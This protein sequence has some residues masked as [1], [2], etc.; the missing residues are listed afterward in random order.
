MAKLIGYPPVGNANDETAQWT[1]GGILEWTKGRR[2]QYVKTTTG[3]LKG[4]AVGWAT[5]SALG[6]V[7]TPDRSAVI[8]I[9]AVK[10]AAGMILNTVTAN[11]YTWI[12]ISGPTDNVAKTNGSIVVDNPINMAADMV[13]GPMAG[14]GTLAH[15][16]SGYAM[17]TDSG[18]IAKLFLQCG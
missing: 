9:D 5:T 14:T 1:L 8:G 11:Y 18:S 12:Q 16:K 13:F 10:R 7:V 2:V 15:T 17:N 4:Y 3:N 6:F